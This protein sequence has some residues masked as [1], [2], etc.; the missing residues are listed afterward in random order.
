MGPCV[1]LTVFA[2]WSTGG[3]YLNF[4]GDEGPDKVRAGFGAAYERLARVKADW[5]PDNGF[6]GNQ[7]IR[8]AQAVH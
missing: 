7:N 8:P 4:I 1:A 3:T 6:R 2:P 5:D